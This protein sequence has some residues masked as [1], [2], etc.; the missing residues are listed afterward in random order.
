MP[1]RQEVAQFLNEFKGAASD[2]NI[3]RAN[4]KAAL[5]RE[6]LNDRQLAICQVSTGTD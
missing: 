5:L 3:N 4:Q 1:N 6:L 2:E